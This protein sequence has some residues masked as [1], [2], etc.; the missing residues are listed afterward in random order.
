LVCK[1]RPVS[2]HALTPYAHVADVQRSIEFYRRLGLEP[3]N[4]HPSEGPLAWAFVTSPGDDPNRAHA[5]LMLGVSDGPTETDKEGVLFYCWTHDVRQLR[6]ELVRAGIE[7]GEVRQPFYMPAG[8]FSVT[9]PDGY[10]VV[11][12]QLGEAPRDE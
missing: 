9:D 3:R 8:E 12:G 1:D 5:R 11:I 4:T 2:I 6:D 7:A 10:V